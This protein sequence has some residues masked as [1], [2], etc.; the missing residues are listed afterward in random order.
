M[1]FDSHAH[2]DRHSF[3][4]DLDA[5][6][7][8]AF[9]AGVTGIVTVGASADPAHMRE[10]ID[11][12]RRHDRIRAAVG[13]H[14][15]AADAATEASF[16][17]LAE[18]L[19]DP[20]V[21]ALGET[22]LDFHYDLS[23]R[24][25]Q[26]RVFGRQVALAAEA[27][28]PLVIHCRE[29]EEECLAVLAAGPLPDPPGVIHCF[30]GDL[31]TARR[32]LELGFVLS[33]PGIV[34]FRKGVDAL[35][36]AVRNVPLDRLLVETDAPWL[37]PVP[38]RGKGRNEPA[39][40]RYTVEAVARLRGLAIEDVARV[41]A[42]NAR[43][44][45]G[46]AD[47][48]AEQ[49]RL[50][51]AIRDSLYVNVTNRCTLR[52]TFCPKWKDW[53]V[54]GHNLRVGRDPGVEELRAA[55]E[56]EGI[57]KYKEIVFCGYGEPLLRLD[58]V[59]SL[60][61]WVKARG[62]RTRVNTD[63]LASL[64]HGRDV[65]AELAG[66]IDSVSVSLNAPDPATYARCCPSKYHEAAFDAVRSFILRCRDFIPEVVATVVDLPGLDIDA[67]RRLAEEELGVPLRVRPYND[68]G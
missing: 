30:G 36:D 18:L 52:C 5:V 7:A 10:A 23:S 17:A 25:G 15:H 4:D 3:G 55:L 13:I 56:A 27:G 22:G 28:K 26:R 31:A 16:A 40:V 61:A 46:I 67:T 43:R 8:R 1:F 19:P 41:T 66:L 51:Y 49:P 64:V 34:T 33:I 6:I 12:A 21:V 14:P 29:A 62:G 32:W 44:L 63:G 50:V 42:L 53:Y 20:L 65:P 45:F 58:V 11:L 60:A 35:H 39:F 24:E 38:M 37:A 9:D 68:M 2:L 47:P 57:E 59:A 48:D 54:K